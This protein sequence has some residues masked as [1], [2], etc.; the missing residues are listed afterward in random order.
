[1]KF[2]LTEDFSIRRKTINDLNKICS[3]YCGWHTPAEI[4]PLWDELEAAGV[5]GILI[6]G[7]PNSVADDGGKSWEVRYN[8]QDSTMS[9]PEEVDNSWFIYQV[10]EGSPDSLKNDYNIYFS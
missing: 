5:T 7:Y 1:M 3:K 8:Y 2:L 4:R 9:S 6:M 10:Y